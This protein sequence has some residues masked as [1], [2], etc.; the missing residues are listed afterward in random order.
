MDEWSLL[1]GEAV[2]DVTVAP[3]GTRRAQPGGSAAN[4]AVGLARLGHRVLLGTCWGDDAPGRSLAEHLA[5]SAVELAADPVTLARTPSAVARIDAS[6]HPSYELDVDWRLG[7]L[8][9]PPT[10]PGVIGAGSFAAV[11]DAGAGGGQILAQMRRLR[12]RSLRFYDVNVRAVVTGVGADVRAATADLLAEADLVK[13]SDE[14]LDL[15]WP[16]VPYATVIER[17][18]DLG[19]GAVL[20]SRGAA[21]VSWVT[22]RGRVDVAAP[23]VDVVDTVGAGDS[24]SSA[25]LHG[26]LARGV[27]SA[28]A[29]GALADEQVREVL[30]VGVRAAGITVSRP[31]ANPPRLDELRLAVR[32][33]LRRVAPTPGRGR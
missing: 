20:L 1:I 23:R 33:V 15:L 9:L 16:G 3:D 31:G 22:R 13:A 21:G 2:Y 25:V 18:W 26:L 10:A 5:D 17:W 24:L 27:S 12:G 28:R 32:P 14:D 6:G 19:V 7:P 8:A 29:L 4:Q 11:L 30:E